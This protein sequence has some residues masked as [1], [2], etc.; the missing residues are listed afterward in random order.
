MTHDVSSDH[1]A[2]MAPLDDKVDHVRGG[3][4]EIHPHALAASQ[5]AE[6]AALQHRFWEMHALL[7]HHQ[8][9]LDEADLSGYAA[10]LGLDVARFDSDRAS[11]GVLERIQS[12]LRFLEFQEGGFNE[13]ANVC[14]I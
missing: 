6:A 3:A 10:Q 2:G 1:G 14:R 12:T 8:Q 13:R 7:F 11:A 4:T 9:A 5:G